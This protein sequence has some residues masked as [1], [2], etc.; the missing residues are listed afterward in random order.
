VNGSIPQLRG[1]DPSLALLK[2]PLCAFNKNWYNN[3]VNAEMIGA[4]GSV[5]N[6][7]IKKP[8]DVKGFLEEHPL[9]EAIAPTYY[10]GILVHISPPTPGLSANSIELTL[11]DETSSV[12]APAM[13]DIPQPASAV[14]VA[15]AQ[16]S[17]VSPAPDTAGKSYENQLERKLIP[18]W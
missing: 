14:S 10:R 16:H 1:S 7:D 2:I 13:P 12:V 3:P 9:K 17:N 11:F 5:I 4:Y 6:T 15:E 18:R 8:P